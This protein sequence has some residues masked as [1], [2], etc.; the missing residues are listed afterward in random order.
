MNFLT[1]FI[2]RLRTESPSFFKKLQI[3]TVILGVVMGF[4]KIL[5]D[6]EIWLPD[7]ASLISDLSGY[8]AVFSAAVF[9]TSTLPVKDT[10]VEKAMQQDVSYVVFE[11]GTKVVQDSGGP[12]LT[13]ISQSQDTGKVLCEWNEGV[14]KRAG[15]FDPTKLKLVV[16][17]ESKAE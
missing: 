11:A 17:N 16:N 5:V 13:V 12:V 10:A 14:L 7:Y 9:G 15:T 6:N 4:V 1:E 2:A 3:G 8:L